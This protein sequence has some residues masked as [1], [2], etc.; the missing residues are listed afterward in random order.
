[1]C[2]APKPPKQ[3]EPLKPQFMRNKYLD[4]FLGDSGAVNALKTGRNSLRIPLASDSGRV[5][6]TSLVPQSPPAQPN[7][8]AHPLRP[9]GPRAGGRDRP[10]TQ[11]R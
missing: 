10:R 8:V 6:G 1:M 5:P 2:K 3:K 4:A 11:L 7:P 9:I